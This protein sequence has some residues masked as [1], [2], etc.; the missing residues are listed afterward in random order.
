M[1]LFTKQK[2]THR[3]RCEFTTLNG[4]SVVGRGKAWIGDLYSATW[5]QEA[6][7]N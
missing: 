2:Q 5:A 6:R 4:L 1:N 7:A 3:L